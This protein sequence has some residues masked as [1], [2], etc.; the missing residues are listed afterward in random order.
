MIRYFLILFCFISMTASCQKQT[1][2]TQDSM[3][4]PCD[5]TIICTMEF[6]IIGLEVRD[7]SGEAVS[8]DDFYTEI[9]G[10][11]VVIPDDV[12][13]MT[14]GMYPVA[15]DGQMKDLDFEGN[16]VFFIG[17]QNGK[18][19]VKHE[20]TIGKDCCHIQLLKGEKSIVISL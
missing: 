13:Q 11:K 20:M 7:K 3:R 9:E 17:F 6:K 12:Y 5:P 14:N 18:R 1:S 19:V 16:K 2:K 8:L 15:T 4:E 10:E